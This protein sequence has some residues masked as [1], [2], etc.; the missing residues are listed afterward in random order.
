MHAAALWVGPDGLPSGQLQGPEDQLSVGR[1]QDHRVPGLDLAAEQLLAERV[2]DQV[3]TMARR[4]G[5]AP[6]SG[7]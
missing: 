3:D 2:L 1:V 6:Y 5:L 7:S 4:R